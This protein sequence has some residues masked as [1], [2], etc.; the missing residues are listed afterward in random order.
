VLRLAGALDAGRA[1]ATLTA[2]ELHV[3]LPRIEERRGR[4]VPIPV[5]VE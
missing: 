4:E 3:V 5:R 2:G 1:H